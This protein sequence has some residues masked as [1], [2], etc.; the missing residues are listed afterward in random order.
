MTE[1]E[2]ADYFKLNRILNAKDHK[3]RAVDPMQAIMGIRTA[4]KKRTGQNH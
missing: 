2:E 1:Y 3:S 4:K